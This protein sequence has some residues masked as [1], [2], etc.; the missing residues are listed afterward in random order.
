[1]EGRLG[2]NSFNKR[3]GLLISDLW[4]NDGLKWQCVV[5]GGNHLLW[6]FGICESKD[7]IPCSDWRML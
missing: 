2:Y 5:S 3:Y 1:M 7:L 6:G 4:E